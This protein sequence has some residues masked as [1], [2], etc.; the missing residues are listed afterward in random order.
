MD[1]ERELHFNTAI[2]GLAYA[3]DQLDLALLGEKRHLNDQQIRNG[4]YSS[5]LKAIAEIADGASIT[6]LDGA[7]D[8]LLYLF[9]FLHYL[10]GGFYSALWDI[11]SPAH[12]L[13]AEKLTPQ[14]AQAILGDHAYWLSL[15]ARL[16]HIHPIVQD[17]NEY[18]TYDA[19][20]LG[21]PPEYH[22]VFYARHE[23]EA[24]KRMYEKK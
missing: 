4:P 11:L 8:D 17:E 14:E 19:T 13:L 18:K 21:D 12:L 10:K 5:K 15:D 1:K 3:A 16:G 9:G 2:S 22:T 20:F 24:R 23:I 6:D 7:R